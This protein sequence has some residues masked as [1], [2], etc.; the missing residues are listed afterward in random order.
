MNTFMKGKQTVK[1]IAP[2]VTTGAIGSKITSFAGTPASVLATVQPLSSDRAIA[3][4]GT[5]ADRMK[6]LIL[7]VGTVIAEGYGVWLAADSTSLPPWRC[8]F[9]S[10]WST[11]VEAHIER[12]DSVA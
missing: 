3:E 6:L 7:P 9:V 2:S 1:I 12:R 11:Q 8:V 4:Y 10:A 5:R